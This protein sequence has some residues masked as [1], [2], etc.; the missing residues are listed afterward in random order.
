MRAGKEIASQVGK[1][2]SVLE[3]CGTFDRQGSFVIQRPLTNRETIIEN[4]QASGAARGR[5]GRPHR[6]ARCPVLR[7]CR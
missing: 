7:G 3:K 4:G 5:A 2:A 1:E 6:G